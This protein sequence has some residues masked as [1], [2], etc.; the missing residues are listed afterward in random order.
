MFFVL[1][2]PGASRDNSWGFVRRCSKGR[3]EK[4]RKGEGKETE[5]HTKRRGKA[6]EEVLT[7][8]TLRVANL[9]AV[10]LVAFLLGRD[11]AAEV[12]FTR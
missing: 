5:R 9:F 1:V 4:K 11:G 6:V 10:A 12:L 8:D 7:R 2:V 3:K